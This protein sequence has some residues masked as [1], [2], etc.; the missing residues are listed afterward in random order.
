MAKIRAQSRIEYLGEF[1]GGSALDETSARGESLSK[2][3]VA[4]EIRLR[5][6]AERKTAAAP[7]NSAQLPQQSV[8]KGVGGLK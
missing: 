7:S 8:E 3:K 1:A 5:H 6:E 4:E 2:A